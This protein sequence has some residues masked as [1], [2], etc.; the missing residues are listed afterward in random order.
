MDRST[1]ERKYKIANFTNEV[2]YSTS[3]GSAFSG[4]L[5]QKV[6]WQGELSDAARYT[7]YFLDAVDV[8][9]L[10]EKWAQYVVNYRQ[11]YPLQSTVSFDTTE[12]T[13]STSQFTNFGTNLV[14]GVII[15]PTPY[16][17]AAVITNY[18]EYHNLRDLLRDKMDE[19]SYALTDLID[20]SIAEGLSSNNDST[21]TVANA[22]QI[23]GG[24]AT[25][26]AALTTGMVLTPS[27]IN[28]AEVL[29]SSKY[30]YYWNGSTFAKGTG[31]KN[32]WKN[33]P[34]DPFVLMIGPRQKQ[35]LR[36]SA[37]FINASQYGDR[38]VISSGEIGDYLGIRVLVSNN[39]P[40]EA[41]GAAATAAYVTANGSY[42]SNT[43]LDGKTS[44]SYPTVDITR[45]FLMKGRAAYTF[46]WGRTPQF[47]TWEKPWADMR[48]ITL[49][50]DFA[51]SIV[52]A[53]A[54]VKIDVSDY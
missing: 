25:N 24:S 48:G 34:T 15:R 21:S 3:E 12:L 44:A 5:N 9:T 4:Y 54:M 45:C 46:V 28:Q 13:D 6:E 40:T 39:I 33:E 37:Q 17:K 22:I 2:T 16:S 8:R 53:D 31:I 1:F 52:H 51:G 14:N 35:A 7:M 47:L 42:T 27:L 11:Y 18:G 50:C 49:V 41:S 38:V 36:D 26:D 23:Y 30:Q 43:T 10:P 19:L 32:P 20:V 29:L